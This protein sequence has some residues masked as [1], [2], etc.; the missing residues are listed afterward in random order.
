M[1]TWAEATEWERDWHGDC[2]NSLGEEYKQIAYA[3]R[4]G[5]RPF[6]NGKSPFNFN[7][8]GASVLDI[9]GGPYSLLLKCVNTGLRYIVDPCL[10]PD[11]VY[12]R[13]RAAGIDKF[14]QMKGEDLT[15]VPW[16]LDEV[17]IYNC[18]QHTENPELIVKNARRIG[19]IVRLFEWIETGVADGHLH[20]LTE[21]TLNAWLGGT[22]KVERINENTAVGL[23]YYGIFLGRE[24]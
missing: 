3:R 14:L 6:H 23:C 19:K 1:Q 24:E 15:Q 5:L 7:L 12:A 11:W 13:Y 4:M 18:L 9:G 22:G 17:W 20:N 21:E 16:Q 2:V 8:N 10:Y